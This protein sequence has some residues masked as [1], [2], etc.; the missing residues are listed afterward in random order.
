MNRPY[1]YA[2]AHDLTFSHTSRDVRRALHEGYLV[3]LRG[4]GDYVLHEVSFPYVSRTTYT[5][6]RR[7]AAQYHRGCGEKLVITSAVRPEVAQPANSSPRSVHP[8][9]IAVDL[10]RPKGRC[11]R[12][13][14]RVLLSLE[15]RGLVEATEEHHPAHFHV[16]IFP[17]A[18]RQYLAGVQGG[19]KSDVG[20]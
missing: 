7:L 16:A 20:K 17:A 14:R 5:F 1:R 9:G 15:R 2:T 19:E 4:G 8:T 6:V 3:R 11:L 10:R 18:Y 13:L 12:W